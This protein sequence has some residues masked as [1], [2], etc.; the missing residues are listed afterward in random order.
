MLL[1][2]STDAQAQVRKSTRINDEFPSIMRGVRPLGMGNA[3]LA[4]P[5]GDTIAQFYNP[6]AINDFEKKRRY[7]VVAPVANFTPSFFDITGDLLDLRH[8]LKSAETPSQKIRYFDTFTQKHTGDYDSFNT[9]M[10]L[11]HV[12]H[13][14]YSAGFIVDGR[15]VISL[16][17]Q[18]FPNFDFK[19][20]N[21][22]GFVGGSAIGLFD[23]SLQIGGNLKALFRTG[24]E[25]Q[26][27]T[28][29]ILIYSIK[30]LIGLN[31]W[32]K[33]FGVGADAGVKY[34]LPVLQKSLAPTV[35]V[36]VQDIA[37]TRFTG[38]VQ[39]M[40]MSVSVGAGIFPLIGG[41]QFAVLVDFRELNRDLNL[42]TKF[43]A[44]VEANLPKIGKTSI[45]IRAGCNEGYFAGGFTMGWGL[46]SIDFAAYGEEAGRYT[47][48][49]PDYRVAT[50]M[51][52][53][54]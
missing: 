12:R 21:T 22:M 50:S 3:F 47:Y 13:K 33:G 6:A 19:T 37:N 5:G 25:D 17:N 35:A 29:D 36:T 32:N 16:R 27:T 44:G 51:A 34:R 38:G 7:S 2:A 42:L 1:F 8:E 39:D 46:Y 30:Q 31:A 4:M 41:N 10:A 14:Y 40:P 11:F 49:R 24:I 48:S 53:N 20:Y 18:A 9:G 52:F 15:A 23:D 26:I 28:S 54:W 43:H 45:A